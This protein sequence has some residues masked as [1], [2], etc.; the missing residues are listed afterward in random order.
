MN[1][2]TWLILCALT[3]LLP[4][5]T[6]TPARGETPVFPGFAAGT[7][8]YTVF[9]SAKDGGGKHEEVLVLN[10]NGAFEYRIDSRYYSSKA[11]NKT[12]QY[13]WRGTWRI[14]EG[15]LLFSAVVRGRNTKADMAAVWDIVGAGK[16]T[17]KLN[18]RSLPSEG[19]Y[20][21]T[22]LRAR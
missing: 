16:D 22:F 7:W 17:L 13:S 11:G 12:I 6:A 9:F 18:P 4:L 10:R 14:E 20:E 21:K 2:T 5:Y 19:G 15:K 8:N 3:I 1:K